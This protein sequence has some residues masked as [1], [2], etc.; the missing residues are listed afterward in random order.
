MIWVESRHCS[1]HFGFETFAPHLNGQGFANPSRVRIAPSLVLE[2]TRGRNQHNN[3][4]KGESQNK[5]E[6]ISRVV[7]QDACLRGTAELRARRPARCTKLRKTGS[8]NIALIRHC[9]VLL[10]V[11]P[12]HN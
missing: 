4:R 2:E 10:V 8:W 3:D 6:A 5:D 11:S 9:K 12:G 7:S 1:H